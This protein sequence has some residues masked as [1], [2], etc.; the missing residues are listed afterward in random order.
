MLQAHSSELVK[1]EDRLSELKREEE[2]KIQIKAYIVIREIVPSS[3]KK[4]KTS[5]CKNVKLKHHIS[6]PEL[7]KLF[8]SP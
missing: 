8:V 4:F 6:S 5:N 1:R 7:I 2:C 3:G